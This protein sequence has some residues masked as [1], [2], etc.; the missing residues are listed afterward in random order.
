MSVA[1]QRTPNGLSPDATRTL[2]DRGF[3]FLPRWKTHQQLLTIARS[4]GTVIDMSAAIP[5]SCIPT[6]QILEPRDKRVAP[7]NQYSAA[8]GLSE[9]PLHT[10]LAH[11]IQPPRYALVRCISGSAAVA[12]RLLHYTVAV[13][14]IGAQSFAHAIFRPRRPP[15]GAALS[16]L[17]MTLR[18]AS[19]HGMR[20]DPIFIKPMNTHASTVAR[21][22]KSRCWWED[23]VHSVPLTQFGDTLLID[24]WRCLHGRSEVP[25]PLIGRKLERVYLSEI[26]T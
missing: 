3:V 5:H 21:K 11:W 13:Q 18:S 25:P 14:A 16:L 4:I 22:M 7:S 15:R 19:V 1:Q 20:W 6:V 9:F 10:D 23:R 17:P 12:T 8:F 2:R 24:N 26:K